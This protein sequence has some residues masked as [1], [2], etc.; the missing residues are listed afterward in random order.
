MVVY[1]FDPIAPVWNLVQSIDN[2]GPPHSV[3]FGLT[4]V[5]DEKNTSLWIFG[6][7][8][9]DVDE[10]CNHACSH[11]GQGQIA[12]VVSCLSEMFRVLI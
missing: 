2:S 1:S 10:S 7:D 11:F 8:E 9:I 5:S 3:G 4:A 12:K 6:G